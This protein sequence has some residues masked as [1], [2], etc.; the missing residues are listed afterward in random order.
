MRQRFTFQRLNLSKIVSI[1]CFLSP[2]SLARSLNHSINH[3]PTYSLNHPGVGL[4]WWL[5]TILRCMHVL[6]PMGGI[7]Q[8]SWW[9]RSTTILVGRPADLLPLVDLLATN[10]DLFYPCFSCNNQKNVLAFLVVILGRPHTT[11][12]KLYGLSSWLQVFSFFSFL[13]IRVQQ[14]SKDFLI[15]LPRVFISDL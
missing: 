14:P 15:L 7:K 1:I 8:V 4:Q 9:S 13:Q 10:S 12:C 5:S 11:L 3:S 6:I 2:H